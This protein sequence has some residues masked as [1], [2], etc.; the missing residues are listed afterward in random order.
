MPNHGRLVLK[1]DFFRAGVVGA[2]LGW[3]KSASMNHPLDKKMILIRSARAL[4]NCSNNLPSAAK[5][6][7][8]TLVAERPIEVTFSATTGSTGGTP[9]FSTPIAGDDGRSIV[10]GDNPKGCR[11]GT[12]NAASPSTFASLPP[13]YDSSNIGSNL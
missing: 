13:T 11:S 3:N 12:T 1:L 4:N 10:G 7:N 2:E 8:R 5:A 6:S 9:R